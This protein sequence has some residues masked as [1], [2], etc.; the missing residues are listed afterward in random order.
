[1]HKVTQVGIFLALGSSLWA[2]AEGAPAA[3]GQSPLSAA[4]LYGISFERGE[5]VS[6]MDAAA[7][8][9][10]FQC[11]ADGTVFF[12]VPLPPDPAVPFGPTSQLTSVSLSREVFSFPHNHIPDLYDVRDASYYASDLKVVFLV[13]AAK[14]DKRE[15]Q[16]LTKQDGTNAEGSLNT[17][18]HHPYALIF[19]REG[20]FQ[21]AVQLDD[22]FQIIN[23]AIF[24]S[25][26]FL[27]YGY[28]ESDHAFKL[29]M[30]KDDGRFIKFLHIPAGGAPESAFVLPAE[31]QNNGYTTI[32]PVQFVP[33]GRNII[34]VQNKSSFPLLEI[35]EAGTIRP[36]LTKLPDGIQINALISS[37]SG[38]YARGNERD[39]VYELS[40][41]DGTVLRRFKVSGHWE[42]VNLACVH[43][44]KFLSFD[45]SSTGK[46]IPLFGSLEPMAS[47][48][49]LTPARE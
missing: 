40:T 33:S 25:E 29:A 30:L 26:T 14:E 45:R 19:D 18:E 3:S 41:Q 24:P 36:I 48:A 39:T 35:N 32:A 46:L 11:N 43:D 5:E 2:G 13:K 34:V 42:A 7:F 37:D 17:A 27:A 1:M 47:P 22:A 31:G 49:A 38:L 15:M 9:L 44:K 23:L 4:P 8:I 28:N 21:E 10:P 16:T 20:E 12:R 6:G